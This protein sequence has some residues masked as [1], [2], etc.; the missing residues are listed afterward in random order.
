VLLSL[1]TTDAVSGA[2]ITLPV[3]ATPTLSSPFNVHTAITGQS[4][5][6]AAGQCL[7][8]GAWLMDACASSGLVL[9]SDNNLVLYDFAAAAGWT[10]AWQSG[11]S[12][13][14]SAGCA[15][16]LC[17]DADGT[18]AVV[19]GKG[20]ALWT[21]ELREDASNVL[22]LRGGNL[23]VQGSGSAVAWTAPATL[24]SSAQ[25]TGAPRYLSPAR[26]ANPFW[27]TVSD[28]SK[29]ATTGASSLFT[30]LPVA[31]R[32][33]PTIAVNIPGVLDT[34]VVSTVEDDSDSATPGS[35]PGGFLVSWTATGFSD[36]STLVL[37]ILQYRRKR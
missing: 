21:A 26:L 20:D 4:D 14:S 7:A 5:S 16:A 19:T 15:S 17:M 35:V 9:G 33:V 29:L 28:A 13:A 22:R 37:I 11:T 6:L 8:A 36:S 3:A 27:F 12:G 32:P 30:L 34:W 25:C 2:I 24:T 18:L 23:T 31:P 10:V 1:A